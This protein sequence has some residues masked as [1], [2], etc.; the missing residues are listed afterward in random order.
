MVNSM[1]TNKVSVTRMA[2]KFY[3]LQQLPQFL[4]LKNAKQNTNGDKV[5]FRDEI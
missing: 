1:Q 4:G 2:D 5:P 3:D